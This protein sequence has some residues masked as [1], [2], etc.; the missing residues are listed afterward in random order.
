MIRKGICFWSY[1]VLAIMM[2]G[3]VAMAGCDSGVDGYKT[4]TLKK[5]I[6][7][8]SFEYSARYKVEKTEVRT[9]LGYIDVTF[10]GP[11]KKEV[12]D[13]TFMGVFVQD[14]AGS[15]NAEASL[16]KSLLRVARLPDYK[17]LDQSELSVAGVT[18]QQIVYFYD[19][20][21]RGLP[22]DPVQEPLPTI[23][24]KVYFDHGGLIWSLAL[25]SNQATAEGDWADFEHVLETFRILE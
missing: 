16:E 8:F 10:T 6:G 14:T 2:S 24:R 12:G 23:M 19:R 9:D 13:H 11:F 21:F 3:L 4:F 1:A 18:G 22:G 5:G 7:H 20:G 15:P 17:L 25:R